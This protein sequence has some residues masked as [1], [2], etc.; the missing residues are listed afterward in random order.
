M[1]VLD[2]SIVEGAD[3]IAELLA[4]GLATLLGPEA[5][6]R[7]QIRREHY[8]PRVLL[9][10]D[11]DGIAAAALVSNRPATAALKIVDLW[12][13]D[14]EHADAVLGAVLALG[15]RQGAAVIKWEVL[16]TAE[17]PRIGRSHGFSRMQPTGGLPDGESVH[18]YAL[19]LSPISHCEPRYYAQSTEFT[20]GAVAALIAA[21]LAGRPGFAGDTG[22]RRR[23]IDFWRA[24]SNYPACEPVGLAVALRRHLV[25]TGRVELAVHP[26]TPV[27]LDDFDGFD[28]EF[29][30]ELQADSRRLAADLQIPLHPG[31][32]LMT[33]LIDRLHND[34]IVLL[35][36]DQL[37][38]HGHREP[39]WVTAFAGLGTGMVV[40][41]DPWI[42]RAGGE[43]WV[44]A[45]NLPIPVA[46]L[47]RM[48]VWGDEQHRG[49]VF[50]ALR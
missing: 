37:A 36:I 13:R 23:E 14:E 16:A 44:D 30:L 33:E 31:R 22:D 6:A 40:V 39:H 17:L 38:M 41:Q 25:D 12:F 11:G 7:W 29:R 8:Q 9:S 20:C 48:C 34:Q 21:E 42:D 18:G 19:W 4:G 24:A 1:K 47:D 45:H 10:A 50:V 5:A 35:L 2:P 43:T 32:V 46:E 27:L 28:R 3:G 49:M 15:Q 26:D